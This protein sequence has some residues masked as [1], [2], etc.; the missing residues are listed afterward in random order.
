MEERIAEL[1]RLLAAGTPGPWEQRGHSIRAEDRGGMRVGMH[2]LIG[3]IFRPDNTTL[4]VA[5][6]NSLPELLDELDRLRG[7]Q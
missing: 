7:A 5:A 6:V 1:R 3:S 2:P 4:I